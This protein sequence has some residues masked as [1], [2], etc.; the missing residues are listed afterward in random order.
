MNDPFFFIVNPKAGGGRTERLWPALQNRLDQ[1]GIPYTWTFTT[2]PKDATQLAQSAPAGHTVV[3]VGGGG[4]LNEGVRGLLGTDSTIGLVP[5]G[6]C[7]DFARSVGISMAPL[8]AVDQLI[9][10][11]IRHIDLPEANGV[12][13]LGTLSTGY[14]VA[15]AKN[16]QRIAKRI[17]VIDLFRL[18][19]AL[20]RYQVPELSIEL[21]GRQCQGPVFL[22]AIGNG[23]YFSG[24][25]NVCP[26]AH[27]D[28]G[29]LD[30][31]V[32]GDLRRAEAILA[33]THLFRGTHIRQR[34]FDYAKAHVIAIDGPD[35]IPVHADGH[36]LGM[37]P[38]NVHVHHRILPVLV[39]DGAWQ[40]SKVTSIW[41]RKTNA[42]EEVLK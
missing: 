26:Q 41:R 38:V 20:P 19:R 39:P 28:D 15:M 27:C 13:F 10:S 34:K 40:P 8:E 16:T 14:G 3:F 30:V 35:H 5:T 7:N 42:D 17:S 33:L 1:K 6:Y 36:S 23:R 2:R 37:L 18:F 32:A 29:L 21:D 9:N 11:Q 31:C 24:G 25:L 22:L 12:P 4:T